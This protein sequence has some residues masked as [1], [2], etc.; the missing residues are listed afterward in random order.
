MSQ[1]FISKN[2]TTVIPLGAGES[3]TGTPDTLASFQEIDITVAGSPEIAPGTL[4]FEFSSDNYHW[5]VSPAR[6]LAGPNIVPIILRSISMYFRVR[7]VNGP[8]PLTELRLTTVLHRSGAM[9]IT[10]FL[11]QAIDVNEPVEMVRVAKAA[12][13]DGAAAEHVTAASPHAV[14]ISDGTSFLDPRDVSDRSGRLLGHVQVDNLPAT[15]PV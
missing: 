14:R 6:M 4:Y 3:F 2:N 10:R 12:L 9:R 1:V 8:V 11:D 5:D 7:Y 15:Q 13:P